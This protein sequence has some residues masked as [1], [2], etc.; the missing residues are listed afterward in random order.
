MKIGIA[1]KLSKIEWD[2]Y[3]LGIS[4][5]AVLKRYEKEGKNVD[6]IVKSHERQRKCIEEIISATD[7]AE[8]IDIN[9]LQKG[10]SKKKEV[11]ILIAIGGDNFFQICAH[12]YDKAYLIGVNSDPLT[13]KGQL[14]N[15]TYAS[16]KKCLTHII[17]GDFQIETW[18]K[19]AVTLNGKRVKDAV[20]IASLPVIDDD[21][22]KRYLLKF[23]GRE[24][25][26]K[27]TGILIVTGAG[28]G[29][30]A[31]YRSAGLYLP[32]IKLGIYP[33]PTTEF[34]KTARQIKTITREPFNH[35][36]CKYKWLNL[37]LSESEELSLVYWSGQTTK[38]SI[39]SVKRYKVNEGDVLT[40]RVSE[41]ILKVVKKT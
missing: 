18:T 32:L 35:E 40:F 30:G 14:L 24:E 23:K 25:E 37:T 31:W 2:M 39:D 15:F 29:D 22:M 12:Y 5:D 20:C 41:N 26:Q 16:L 36:K 13:S 3:R 17:K 27:A 21:I 6:K 7:N 28:S 33:E 9:D 11:D 34:P 10:K 19:I 8:I 1:A 38:L 4:K